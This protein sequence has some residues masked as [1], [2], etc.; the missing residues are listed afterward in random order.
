MNEAAKITLWFDKFAS[1]EEHLDILKKTLSLNCY[2]N[3]IGIKY[4]TNV[5]KLI[6]DNFEQISDFNFEN[7]TE[8]SVVFYN[9][10]KYTLPSTSLRLKY[11]ELTLIDEKGNREYVRLGDFKLEDEIKKV[12]E[13]F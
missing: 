7:L 2:V 8:D 10:K 11:K 1:I 3:L 13:N 12:F 5:G 4:N 9:N 6:V